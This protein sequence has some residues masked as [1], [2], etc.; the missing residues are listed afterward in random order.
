MSEVRLSLKHGFNP[1]RSLDLIAAR[2][3]FRSSAR[4]PSLFLKKKRV[5]LILAFWTLDIAPLPAVFRHAAEHPAVAYWQVLKPDRRDGARWIPKVFQPTASPFFVFAFP[6]LS[7][8]I[9]RSITQDGLLSSSKL[10]RLNRFQPNAKA[11]L[12]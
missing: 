1:C 8:F 10:D 7:S 11:K 5:L 3:S 6:L 2:I 4:N 9:V 12:L